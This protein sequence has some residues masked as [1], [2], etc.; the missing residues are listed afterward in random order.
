MPSVGNERMERMGLPC[1]CAPESTLPCDLTPVSDSGP[2]FGENDAAQQP[3][4]STDDLV[5][6]ARRFVEAFQK[7]RITSIH[8]SVVAHAK[9]DDEAR[10]LFERF[11]ADWKRD[12]LMSS[13]LTAIITHPAYYKIIAMGKLALPFILKSLRDGTG[14]WFVALEAIVIDDPPIYPE[15]AHDGNL[16]RKD[17]LDWAEAHGYLG[18]ERTT[19]SAEATHCSL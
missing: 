12:T 8:F 6:L 17:W 15:H 5:A 1:E 16:I 3:R 13:N 14:P 18:N 2:A 9:E 11:Y 19:F 4:A 7:Q 10:N